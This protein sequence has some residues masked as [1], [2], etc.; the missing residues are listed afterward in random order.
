MGSMQ[1]VVQ[2]PFRGLF[3]GFWRYKFIIIIIII[4]VTFSTAECSAFAECGFI[5]GEYDRCP[6]F[7]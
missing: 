2:F 1:R 4:I 3:C 5:V 7:D 6:S